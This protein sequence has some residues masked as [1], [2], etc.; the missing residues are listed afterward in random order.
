MFLWQVMMIK[1]EK[2]CYSALKMVIYQKNIFRKKKN[3][4]KKKMHTNAFFFQVEICGESSLNMKISR[5]KRC[6][7]TEFSQNS[8]FCK[9]SASKDWHPSN[10]LPEHFS[11]STHY[12]WHWPRRQFY[13]HSRLHIFDSQAH[14]QVECERWCPVLT[15]DRGIFEGHQSDTARRSPGKQ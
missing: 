5:W 2:H 4:S 3:A 6:I 7:F 14:W 13:R 11:Q 12:N 9:F 1:S 8:T 15:D 10:F